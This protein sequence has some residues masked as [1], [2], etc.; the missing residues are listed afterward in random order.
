M[1]SCPK[2]S[3]IV[4]V[5]NAEKFIERCVESIRC[6][7]F[8]DFELLLIDDGSIDTSLRLCESLALR[9]NRI[10][11][12]HK[13]NG[14]ANSAR[15]FGVECSNGIYINFVDADDVIPNNALEIL[16]NRMENTDGVDIIQAASIFTPLGGNSSVQS[17]YP[18][19]GIFCSEQF[20]GFLLAAKCQRGPWGNLY[21]RNLFGQETFNL[22][23]DVKLGEDF[24][25]N[26]CLGIE[27][28]KVGI[29]NDIVYC[30]IENHSSVTHNYKFQSIQ[31]F[32]HQLLSIKD[33]LQS[34]HLYDKYKTAYMM[35][36][37]DTLV[38]VCLHNKDL[39]K[40]EFVKEMGKEGLNSFIDMKHKILC[41]MLLYPKIYSLFYFTNIIRKSFIRVNGKFK[42]N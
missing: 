2:V 14:G 39:L 10:L 20:I 24:Y 36:A 9:D 12:F 35:M 15:A 4:P 41:L 40:S 30:Y 17:L 29:Y 13:E 28:K 27:A 19:T 16:L 6:Q 38:S 37:I 3:V 33:I 42:Y 25:M 22:D 1:I 11:V 7:T 8:S 18:Q 31:P 34:R 26:L 5:Y 32:Q 21:K 23:K